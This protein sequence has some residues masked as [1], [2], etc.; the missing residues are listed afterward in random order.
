MSICMHMTPRSVPPRPELLKSFNVILESLKAQETRVKPTDETRHPLV[1]DSHESAGYGSTGSIRNRR[2]GWDSVVLAGHSYGTFVAGWMIRQMVD[3]N[4]ALDAA[5]GTSESAPTLAESL[6]SKIAHVILIDPIP[7]LL[8]NPT[9]AHNFLYR[10]P[11]TVCPRQLGSVQ[12][13]IPDP[14]LNLVDVETGPP[15]PTITTTTTTTQVKPPVSSESFYSSAAAWQ[16]WYFAS[17]DADIARTLFRTFFWTEGGIWREEIEAFLLGG[18]VGCDVCV[19]KNGDVSEAAA[20]AAGGNGD[21]ELQVKVPQK[22]RNMAVF[23]GGMDQIIPAQA[24]RRY[25]TQEDRPAERWM[26]DVG[27]DGITVVDEEAASDVATTR[28]G[29]SGR[30][31]VFFNPQLDH[32]VIFDEKRWTVPLVEVVRRFIRDA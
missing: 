20:V 24:V 2:S 3:I 12:T 13:I 30:L 27:P 7:I 19:D 32:A 6:G 17:R 8:S 23:L 29:K 5:S 14:V 28:E 11:S 10:E 26:G 31:E 21:S 1:S 22:R 18:R 25:L 16:L 15:S 4:I 9:V